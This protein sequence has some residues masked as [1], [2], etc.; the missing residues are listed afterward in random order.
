VQRPA[1]VNIRGDSKSIAIEDAPIPCVKFLRPA[2]HAD[3][4][5]ELGEVFRADLMREC[6]VEFE[7]VQENHLLTSRVGTVRGLHFQIP[8]Y[9]QS[10]LVRVVVGAIFDVAVDLRRGSPTYGQ[11]VAALLSAKEWNQVFV[12]AGFAHGFCTLQPNTEVAYKVDGYRSAES[13]R[14]LLWSDPVL[15]IRWPVDVASITA[16][17]RDFRQPCLR[18]LPQYFEYP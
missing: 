17:E 4:R 1:L 14:G 13:E 5:G 3:E 11:H 6:G 8:P 16:S 15:D 7:P 12:P 18:E 9:A 10:K 2:R